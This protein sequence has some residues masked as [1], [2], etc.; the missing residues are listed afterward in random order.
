MQI[1]VV[2]EELL[3]LGFYGKSLPFGAGFM[4]GFVAHIYGRVST[5]TIQW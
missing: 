2:T 1:I 4:V 5:V 3:I